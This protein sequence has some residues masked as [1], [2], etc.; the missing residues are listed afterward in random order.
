MDGRSVTIAPWWSAANIPLKSKQLC[1]ANACGWHA[2][3]KRSKEAKQIFEWETK[4]LHSDPAAMTENS[5]GGGV[6]L[7]GRGLRS[8]LL[9]R[10]HRPGSVRS[11]KWL[12][13]F[14]TNKLGS[15]VS[16]AGF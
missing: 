8:V 7:A 1:N 4:G 3:N 6:P 13:S 2:K 5:V 10:K 14:R 16:V 9:G 12:P 11:D 15:G